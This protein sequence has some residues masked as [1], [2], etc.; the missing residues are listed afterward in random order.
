MMGGA[1]GGRSGDGP[2]SVD[3]SEWSRLLFPVSLAGRFDMSEQLGGLASDGAPS[4][5]TSQIEREGP[6]EESNRLVPDSQGHSISTYRYLRLA[7]VT[8]ILT[9]LV[10]LLLE[11]RVASCWQGSVSS[12]YYTPVHAIFVAAL[13]VIGVAL[14]A[15]RG[16]TWLEEVLLNMAGFLAPVVAFVPTGWSSSICPSNLKGTSKEIVDRLLKG[17]HFFAKFSGNNLVAFVVGGF[18][19]VVLAAGVARIR[20]RKDRLVPPTELALP[21]LGSAGVV[22]TGFIWHASWPGSFNTH[23]HSYSAIFMFVLVGI[24]MI[25]TAQRDTSTLYKAVYF[26]SA[27]AMAAG[28]VA[29]VVAGMLVTWHHEVLVLEGIEATVF[30]AFWFLQTIQLWDEGLPAPKGPEGAAP[31]SGCGDTPSGPPAA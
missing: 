11:R 3:G 28:F 5:S 30:V 4:S 20:G 6:G 7:I 1:P 19:A 18:V 29:V 25:L 22:V 27:G 14:I 16:G 23:A 31:P 21:A 13:G 8:V 26:A 10:S 9:L 17:N 24:V 15:I 2:W 12:Y